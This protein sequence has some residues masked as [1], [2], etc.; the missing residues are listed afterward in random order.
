[1]C[2]NNFKMTDIIFI[3]VSYYCVWSGPGPR[4]TGRKISSGT[5][6]QMSNDKSLQN[7]EGNGRAP[8][9]MD[10]FTHSINGVVILLMS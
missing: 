6:T 8:R 9:V 2:R 10:Q 1:M 3:N 4:I 5:L 7:I